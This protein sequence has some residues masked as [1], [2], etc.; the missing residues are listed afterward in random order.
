MLFEA[1][2]EAFAG[3]TPA[4]GRPSNTRRTILGSAA[5]TSR[6][7]RALWMSFRVTPMSSAVAIAFLSGTRFFAPS[8]A[9]TTS[10]SSCAA[11]YSSANRRLAAASIS[12]H[13]RQ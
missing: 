2:Y 10:S 9:P 8:W 6:T 5:S 1:V 11:S 7:A 12:A 4:A 3:P 13:Q